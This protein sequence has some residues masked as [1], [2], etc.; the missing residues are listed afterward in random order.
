[1]KI[2]NRKKNK[3]ILILVAIAIL[4]V[5]FLITRT[6]IMKKNI[7][8]KSEYEISLNGM[9]ISLDNVIS[10]TPNVPVVGAGMIPI[11]WNDNANMWEITTSKDS[12]WYDYSAGKFAN[13][14]LSDGY[15]KSELEV[16]IDAK[17]QLMENNIGTQIADT[18]KLRNNL[19]LGTEVNV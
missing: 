16:G 17:L 13:V 1:M 2:K 10:K 4:F 6:K 12:N 8:A 7:V 3:F 19:Y 18:G 11:K 5:L 9:S 15:Y 14:M